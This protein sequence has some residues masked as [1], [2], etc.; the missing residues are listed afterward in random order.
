MTEPIGRKRFSTKHILILIFGLLLI[1]FLSWGI[2]GA[3][4]YYFIFKD[5]PE[6]SFELTASDGR[7]KI[8]LS[9]K[10][11][12]NIEDGSVFVIPLKINNQT[13]TK[14]LID[15][16][17]IEAAEL[18]QNI[19][20]ISSDPDYVNIDLYS[21]SDENE[22]S[23][24]ILTNI[25]I[26]PKSSKTIRLKFEVIKEA[27]HILTFSAWSGLQEYFDKTSVAVQVD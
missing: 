26:K 21:D 9:T 5:M 12:I 18:E 4:S 13:K 16:I 27:D 25:M 7:N 23:I 8:M 24:Y 1:E 6:D 14:L 19:F 2:L 20:F 17:E 22:P 10:R 15:T 3:S 11:A